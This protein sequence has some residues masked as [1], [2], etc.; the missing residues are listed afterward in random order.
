[1]FTD[2]ILAGDGRKKLRRYK[3][4]VKTARAHVKALSAQ[5]ANHRAKG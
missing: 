2:A 1:M 4:S 3:A 5:M